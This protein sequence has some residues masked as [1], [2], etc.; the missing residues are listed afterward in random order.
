MDANSFF[1]E[2]AWFAEPLVEAAD[3]EDNLV[4]FFRL[5]GYDLQAGDTGSIITGFASL[6]TAVDGLV[7]D[8]A[9]AG[10]DPDLEKLLDLFAVVKSI[11]DA[12]S[13]TNYFGPDFFVEVFDYLLYKYLSVKRPALLTLLSILGVLKLEDVPDARDLPYTKVSFDWSRISDFISDTSGWAKE[14]Y[15]WGGNPSAG[16]PKSLDYKFLF[17]NLAAMFEAAGLSLAI[18]KEVSPA[19]LAGFLSNFDPADKH[20]QLSLALIQKNAIGLDAENNP[21]F[22]TEAGFK[23]LPYGNMNQPQNLGFAVAPFVNGT[24]AESVALAEN[25]DLLINISANALGGIFLSISPQ[26]VAL[27][28]GGSISAGFETGV[29]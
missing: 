3:S 22:D 24:V 6:A 13:L 10:E 28:S 16:D 2:I 21:E 15:G 4:K 17:S 18:F 19:E 26:G 1:D 20:Y 27:Q 25:L 11:G 7:E 29:K 8:N 14:V 23:L 5:F 12:S 9:P